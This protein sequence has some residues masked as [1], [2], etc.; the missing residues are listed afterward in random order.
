MTREEDALISVRKYK[1]SDKINDLQPALDYLGGIINQR[2]GQF[3]RTEIPQYV[4][5]QKA[6]EY[7]IEGLKS[8]DPAKGAS[9]GTYTYNQLKQLRRF[10]IKHQNTARIPEHIALQVGEY[11][12]AFEHLKETLERDPSSGELADYLSWPTKRVEQIMTAQRKSNIAQDESAVYRPYY[13]PIEDKADMTYY[14]MTPEEQVIFDMLTGNH[15]YEKHKIA[16]VAKK[17]KKTYQ[18]IYKIKQHIVEK[19]K[20]MV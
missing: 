1:K 7:V 8:Y 16:L 18:Q 3:A 19:L 11:K 17:L 2:A 10:V 6:R 15:G 20:E 12:T 5:Q 14:S 9:L 4:L 13:N